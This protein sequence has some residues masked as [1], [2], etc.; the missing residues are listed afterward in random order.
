VTIPTGLDPGAVRTLLSLAQASSTAGEDLLHEIVE[1][2]AR[3][4]AVRLSS[5][6]EAWRAGRG[7]DTARAAHTLKGAAAQVGA[8][9]VVAAAVDVERAARGPFVPGTMQR[10]RE[11]VTA[12]EAAL[13]TLCSSRG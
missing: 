11:A 8:V 2:F 12:G 6:E 7:A 4:S 5:I 3:D 13:R 1:L 9:D 10:L